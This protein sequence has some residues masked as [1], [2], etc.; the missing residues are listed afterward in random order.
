MWS[1]M[2]PTC[3]DATA[4]NSTCPRP[5]WQ[6]KW[7]A[8][9]R[10]PLSTLGWP[11]SGAGEGLSRTRVRVRWF[12]AASVNNDSGLASSTQRVAT[13]LCVCICM[14]NAMSLCIRPV[15]T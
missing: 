10:L 3:A 15:T 4:C 6:S 13:V 14:L 7:H 2:L 9:A 12:I 8:L 1:K 11:L 5:A